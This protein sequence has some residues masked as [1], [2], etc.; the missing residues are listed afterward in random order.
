ME[1]KIVDDL[2]QL[3][4]EELITRNEELMAERAAVEVRVKAAQM[5]VQAEMDKRLSAARV[6]RALDA[7]TEDDKAA[8]AVHLGLVKTEA[9]GLSRVSVE[10]QDDN[11]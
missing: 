2:T 7:M 4:D 9:P 3:T 1:Q 6:A 8:L 10:G 5:A 11:G